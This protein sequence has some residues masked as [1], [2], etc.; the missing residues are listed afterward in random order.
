MSTSV[1][2]FAYRR[3][4]LETLLASRRKCNIREQLW[5]HED[6]VQVL[7]VYMTHLYVYTGL[8]YICTQDSLLCVHRTHSFRV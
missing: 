3:H 1:D 8:I 6:V 2:H 5:A 4:E 7:C